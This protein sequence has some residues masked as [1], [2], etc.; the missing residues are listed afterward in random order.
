MDNMKM[1]TAINIIEGAT[2]KKDL[3]ILLEA[4][5]KKE[6][7]LESIAE[8]RAR[9]AS[10]ACHECQRQIEKQISTLF[11][12][13]SYGNDL[14]YLRVSTAN[15]AN[16]LTRH[17]YK[18]EKPTNKLPE[19]DDAVFTLEDLDFENMYQDDFRDV[20]IPVTL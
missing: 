11:C 9:I 13:F 20:I 15:M 10:T 2:S 12:D 18:V 6:A 16:Y 1:T 3:E 14:V 4:I 17:G 8:E 5:K 7:N 19:Q